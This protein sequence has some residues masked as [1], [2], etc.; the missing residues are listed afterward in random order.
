LDQALQATGNLTNWSAGAAGFAT[1]E[2][3]IN[4]GRPLAARIAWPKG[5]G[6]FVTLDGY[7]T[8]GGQYLSVKDPFYGTSTYPYASFQSA[9]RGSGSWSHSYYTH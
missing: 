6:H 8:A 7:D 5:G 9:Y 1:V 2:Q 4:A 3:E